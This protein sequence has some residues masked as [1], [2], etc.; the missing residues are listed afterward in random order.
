MK[1]LVQL[2]GTAKKYMVFFPGRH[3]CESNSVTQQAITEGSYM[4]SNYKPSAFILQSSRKGKG[5]G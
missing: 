2:T 1:G 3:L 5:L 4:G